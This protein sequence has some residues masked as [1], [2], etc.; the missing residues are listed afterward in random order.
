MLP[1]LS[2][3]VIGVE[4]T[5]ATDAVVIAD[6]PALPVEPATAP[7]PVLSGEPVRVAVLES[8]LPAALEPV[9]AERAEVVRVP[10]ADATLAAGP[11]AADPVVAGTVAAAPPETVP[12][13]PAEPIKDVAVVITDSVMVVLGTRAGGATVVPEAEA[14]PATALPPEPTVLEAVVVDVIAEAVSGVLEDP[15]IIVPPDAGE[16]AD[17]TVAAV[18]GVD[19]RLGIGTGV[20]SPE[21]LADPCEAGEVGGRVLAEACVEEGL[22]LVIDSTTPG[23]MDDVCEAGDCAS[24]AFVVPEV[25]A[26][27]AGAEFGAPLIPLETA[28]APEVAAPP[29]VTTEVVVV[30]TV[31][32]SELEAAR[33]DA[34]SDA[35]LGGEGAGAAATADVESAG[36]VADGEEDEAGTSATGEVG[37]GAAALAAELADATVAVPNDPAT[38]SKAA[39][40]AVD[41]TVDGCARTAEGATDG[42]A[43][44]T[45]LEVSTAAPTE[46]DCGAFGTRV[47]VAGAMTAAEEAEP[48]LT[49]GAD[50]GTATMADEAVSVSDGTTT[51]ICVNVEEGAGEGNV[52]ET[53]EA[54]GVEDTSEDGARIV[55]GTPPG[56]EVTGVAAAGPAALELP[57]ACAEAL[58]G[59]VGNTMIGALEEDEDEG[60]EDAAVLERGVRVV[61]SEDGVTGVTRD[62]NVGKTTATPD[63]VVSTVCDVPG[64]GDAGGKETGSREVES[65]VAGSAAELDVVG[66]GKAGAGE[67]VT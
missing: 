3:T 28:P 11:V 4:T 30:N 38:G 37:A 64:E 56:V 32:L 16:F 25:V 52:V 14:P 35:V 61:I 7:R 53:T 1:A 45:R 63:E 8:V 58:E 44:L 15:V 43:G 66:E 62:V 27:D 18:D 17:V 55:A 67:V 57:A 26:C 41:D 49:I 22:G 19:E 54:T 13:A 42:A 2:V 59:N 46:E 33:F 36:A 5:I 23:I 40:P 9:P 24:G 65:E 39:E 60:E 34:T 50:E 51:T 10:A 47:E 20:E 6:P 21:P 12:P 48:V 29:A 31:P